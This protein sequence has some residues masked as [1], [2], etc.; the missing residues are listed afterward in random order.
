MRYDLLSFKIFVSN[1]KL[2]FQKKKKKRM[3]IE[4]I[5]FEIAYL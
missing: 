5:D 1:Q 4:N 2:K 3:E